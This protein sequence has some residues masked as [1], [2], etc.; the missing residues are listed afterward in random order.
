MTSCHDGKLACWKVGVLLE[1][2]D[3]FLRLFVSG[4]GPS[5]RARFLGTQILWNEL[6]S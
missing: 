4:Q 6:L 1:L 5:Q 2:L 3:T